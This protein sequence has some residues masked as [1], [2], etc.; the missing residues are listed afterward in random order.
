MD[1]VKASS[2]FSLFNHF[3]FTW[4]KSRV[5]NIADEA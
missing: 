2:T 3:V 5:I 4:I 1:V